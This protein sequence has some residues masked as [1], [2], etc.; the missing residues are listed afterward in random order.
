MGAPLKP[1]SS[2]NSTVAIAEALFDIDDD[3]DW[4]AGGGQLRPVVSLSLGLAV[5][6]SVVLF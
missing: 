3:E 5:V 6:I 1:P 2:G 4:T